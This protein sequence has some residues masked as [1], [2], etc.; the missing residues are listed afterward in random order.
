METIT[1]IALYGLKAIVDNPSKASEINKLFIVVR[2][3]INSGS[4][5]EKESRFFINSINLLKN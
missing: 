4:E 5:I 3:S 2:D 1:D